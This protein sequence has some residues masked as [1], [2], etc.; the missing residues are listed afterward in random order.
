[1]EEQFNS[2]QGNKLLY[3]MDQKILRPFVGTVPVN[4]EKYRT[5]IIRDEN[6]NEV[7]RID[8]DPSPGNSQQ[9][10]GGLINRIAQMVQGLLNFKIGDLSGN[11]IYSI[12][13]LNFLHKKH[14]FSIMNGDETEEK[15][16]A[17]HYLMNLAKEKIEVTD[18]N[19]NI[20]LRSEYRGYRKIIEVQDN[21]NQVASLH[22]PIISMR[23]RWKIE[24]NGDCD[25][26]LVLIMA[27][28]M[29]EMGER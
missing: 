22:A 26:Y 20:L 16:K 24:F 5:K 28:I 10:G 13:S 18:T 4:Y 27:A 19:S 3:M 29:S 25:R 14:D 15:F 17:S 1:M 9:G 2:I 8:Y 21:N 23:D 6:D 11:Y 12:K 7:L